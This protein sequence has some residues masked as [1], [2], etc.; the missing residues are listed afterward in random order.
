MLLYAGIVSA[1]DY[2][3]YHPPGKLIN[4]GMHVMY[5]DLNSSRK[6]VFAQ[7][8]E[9]KYFKERVS[10]PKLMVYHLNLH[11]VTCKKIY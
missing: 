8:N 10:Y 6:A 2:Q 9:L 7:M 5:I 1:N 3:P 4:L 11:G